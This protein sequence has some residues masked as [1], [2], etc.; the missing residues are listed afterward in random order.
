MFGGWLAFCITEYERGRPRL[1]FVPGAR[2]YASSGMVRHF[3][4]VQETIAFLQSSHKAEYSYRGQIQRHRCGVA[5]R[6]HLLQDNPPHP[7]LRSYSES[8]ERI[9]SESARGALVVFVNESLLPSAFRHLLEN[10]IVHWHRY[11]YPSRLDLIASAVRGILGANHAE[12]NQLLDDALAALLDNAKLWKISKL[13]GHAV[14]SSAARALNVP[15]SFAQL[16]SLSQHYDCASSMI[17]T[18]ASIDVA[19]WFATH[20]WQGQKISNGVGVIYRFRLCS[21]RLL[22]EF[23][24]LRG[25]ED[26]ATSGIL[27]SVSLDLAWA[28][29]IVAQ[30]GGAMFGCESLVVMAL[31]AMGLVDVFTFDQ[32]K[33]SW[34]SLSREA[35]VPPKESDFLV[36]VFANGQAQPARLTNI[37]FVDFFSRRGWPRDRQ[38]A[39]LTLR[40]EGRL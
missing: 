7:V 19:A 29:R 9:L 10:G 40:K 34:Q 6:I 36:D 14:N 13:L 38:Q 12:L 3:R 18:T 37:E 16:V 35:L 5:G 23:E 27:G 4:D 1:N 28:P 26:V 30:R 20:S 8:E 17:D 15:A 21:G 32:Q 22:R 2:E 11:S 25:L 33:H 39:F 31:L 24:H